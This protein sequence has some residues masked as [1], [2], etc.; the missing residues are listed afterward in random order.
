MKALALAVSMLSL[1]PGCFFSRQHLNR[2]LDPVALAS[3]VPGRSTAA[4]VVAILGA[5]TDVVQLGQRTAYRYDYLH[6][7]DAAL[8]LIIFA[9][10][11]QEVQADRAWAFFDENEVL[12]HL[13]TTLDG[14]SASYF[15]PPFDSSVDGDGESEQA[16]QP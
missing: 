10:R 4:D 1:T 6:T 5:P 3:L 7:K 9:V 8:F 11:G 16:G 2:P 15:I 14:K 13:G 12:T